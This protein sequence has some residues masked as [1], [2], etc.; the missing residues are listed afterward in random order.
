MGA[1]VQRKLTVIFSADVVG[2]SGLM[3]R[4]ETGTLERLK[5]NRKSV[6]D[7][8]VA[9]HG[10]RIV[11]LMG[12]GTLVE[13]PSVVSAVVC[14]QEIQRASELAPCARE[15]ERIRYRIG[16]NLGEVI[17]DGEDIYGDGVNVAARLQA[18]AVPGEF[19]DLGEH[20]V[21]NIERPIHV[22][23]LRKAS[24][25]EPSTSTAAPRQ[26][27]SICVLP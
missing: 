12:D 17:V 19:I 5:A 15:S 14:A 20:A 25:K 6:F 22:F 7:P 3:E 21:K 8:G 16:I 27:P 4:D 9:A 26:R 24:V 11:K 1:G 18:L 10:G 23:A 2:Y 13:F